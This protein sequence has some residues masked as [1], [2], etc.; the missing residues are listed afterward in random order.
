[1]EF[2]QVAVVDSRRHFHGISVRTNDA[3]EGW[4]WQEN[5]VC[6]VAKCRPYVSMVHLLRKGCLD[7]GLEF[8]IR[9]P[10][11]S[12]VGSGVSVQVEM[13]GK[14]LRWRNHYSG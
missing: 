5:V 7:E 11:L 8:L 13:Y 6:I 14:R 3:S 12:H 4:K 2:M 9:E 1:M 10:R